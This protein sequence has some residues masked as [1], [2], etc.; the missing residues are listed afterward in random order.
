[1]KKIGALGED[2]AENHLKTKKFEIIARNFHCKY[3]EIDIIA[4]K[5]DTIH[6]FEVKTRRE[7]SINEPVESITRQKLNRI[8]KSAMTFMS[9]YGSTGLDAL[10]EKKRK[11]PLL[12]NDFK[13]VK[14][15]LSTIKS[16][17][18]FLIGILLHGDKMGG[19]KSTEI[20]EIEML[21]IC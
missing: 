6:F 19:R 13:K 4:K 1:M 21:D 14:E 5:N 16:W 12:E 8:I 10:E 3:G 18:I 11:S 7:N 17:R 15:K 9:L 20:E 2:I